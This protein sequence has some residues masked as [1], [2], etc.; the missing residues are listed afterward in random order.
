MKRI[1]LTWK[2]SIK[3]YNNFSKSPTPY[4]RPTYIFRCSFYGPARLHFPTLITP[5]VTRQIGQCLSLYPYLCI[6]ATRNMLH[7]INFRCTLFLRKLKQERQWQWQQ[8]HIIITIMNPRYR[9]RNRNRNEANKWARTSFHLF[10]SFPVFSSVFRLLC[11]VLLLL[12]PLPCTPT[13]SARYLPQ[14]LQQ[15]QLAYFSFFCFCFTSGNK[16]K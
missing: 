6:F 12:P 2:N 4:P 8:Q 3:Y 7:N 15:K 13:V 9:Y 16:I 11:G 10:L 1:K 5:N 14:L